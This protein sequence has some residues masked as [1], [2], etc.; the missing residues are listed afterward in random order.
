[1]EKTLGPGLVTNKAMQT[2]G[3]DVESVEAAGEQQAA[4]WG[5]EQGGGAPLHC[6]PS[7]V[8]FLDRVL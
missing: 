2:S 5:S 8:G 7:A 3:R 4:K 1:M 6:F